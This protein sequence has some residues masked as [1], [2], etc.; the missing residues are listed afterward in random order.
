MK[1]LNDNGAARQDNPV[2]TLTK[3]AT[4]FIAFNLLKV[5]VVLAFVGGCYAG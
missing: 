1:P 4:Y 5:L 2:K 3:R